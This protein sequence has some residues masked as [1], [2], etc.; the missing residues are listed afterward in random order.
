M[1]SGGGARTRNPRSADRRDAGSG[2]TA[3]AGAGVGVTGGG[4]GAGSHRRGPSVAPVDVSGA[5]HVRLPGSLGAGL[6]RQPG[7]RGRHGF[8]LDQVAAF[9]RVRLIDEFVVQVSRSGFAGA[10]VSQVCRAVGASTKSFYGAFDSKDGCLLRAFDLGAALVCERAFAAFDVASG[11]W[12]SRVLAAVEQAL[13]DLA[14]N[15]PFARVALVEVPRLGP[16]G[17]ARFDAVVTRFLDRLGAE[18]GVPAAVEPAREKGTG[19]PAGT[20]YRDP[21]VAAA[22]CLLAGRVEAGEASRLAELAPEI[23]RWLPTGGVIRAWTA[24]SD[25]NIRARNGARSFAPASAVIQLGASPD[26]A[27]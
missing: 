20:G 14:A 25:R 7:P 1:P 16:A 15:P 5:T 6:L 24:S 26:D 21:L 23:V 18:H 27:Q 3:S 11:P 9:R 10:H 17:V 4:P 19:L 12:R 13:A 2:A 8:P 22:V